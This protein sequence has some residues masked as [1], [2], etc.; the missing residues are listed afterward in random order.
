MLRT[1]RNLGLTRRSNGLSCYRNFSEVV[2]R[3]FGVRQGGNVRILSQGM[4]TDNLEITTAWQDHCTVEYGYEESL[5]KDFDFMI[6]EDIPQQMLSITAR[7]ST[8]RSVSPIQW[9]KITIP[10]MMNVQIEANR[11]DLRVKNKVSR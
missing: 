6:D 10:E 9:M 4:Q 11:M 2:E 7:A 1:C 5:T 8:I 3:S